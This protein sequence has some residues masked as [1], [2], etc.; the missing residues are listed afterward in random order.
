MLC[1]FAY[2]GLCA[3]VLQ[4]LLLTVL[5][6]VYEL[7][8]SVASTIAFIFA[9]IANYALNYRLTFR[10]AERHT[11]AI[12]KFMTVVLVGITLNGMVVGWL[13]THTMFH[14]LVSQTFATAVV[15]FW[16]FSANMTWTFRPPSST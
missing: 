5:V 12:P 7:R 13:D 6:E 3:T 11:A 16:N 1:K 10:S 9:A 2:V 4:Y 8:V 15:M 14:Y